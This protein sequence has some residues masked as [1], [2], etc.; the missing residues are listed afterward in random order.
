MDSDT[1]AVLIST[2]AEIILTKGLP[3]LVT[4]VNSI[5]KKDTQEPVTIEDIEAV[6]GDLDSEEYFK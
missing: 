1:R 4:F 6:K 2:T 5:N 3:A